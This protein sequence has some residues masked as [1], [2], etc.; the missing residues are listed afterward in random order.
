MGDYFR[1]KTSGYDV[2]QTFGQG[3]CNLVDRRNSRDFGLLL[4]A[5]SGNEDGW[6]KHA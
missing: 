5:R 2:H 6:G 1:L 3:R 4:R